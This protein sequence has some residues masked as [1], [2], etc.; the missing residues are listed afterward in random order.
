MNVQDEK[1]IYPL[2]FEEFGSLSKGF[3]VLIDEVHALEPECFE[4]VDQMN[5]LCQEA[6]YLIKLNSNS[7]RI[8]ALLFLHALRSFQAGIILLCKGME[9]QGVMMLR[10]QTEAIFKIQAIKK[11]ANCID[12]FMKEYDMDRKSFGETALKIH[13]TRG[14]VYSDTE[15]T[16]LKNELRPL[17]N[18]KINKWMPKDWAKKAKLDNLYEGLYQLFSQPVHATA[19]QLKEYVLTENSRR[20]IEFNSFP[21]YKN[22]HNNLHTLNLQYLRLLSCMVMP[23]TRVYFEFSEHFST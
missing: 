2:D 9:A 15:I 14:H 13:N 12:Q 6:L 8:R 11:D 21:E 4:I 7:A 1:E 16:E 17:R 10:A 3:N 18:L 22:L 23:S 5:K 19:H 20:K